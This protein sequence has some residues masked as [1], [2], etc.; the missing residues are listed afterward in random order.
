MSV[1]DRRAVWMGLGIVVLAVLGLRLVPARARS[2]RGLG[3]QLE[4]QRRLVAETEAAVTELP[5]LEDSARSLKQK[6]GLLGEK[7]LTG[8][9]EAEAVADLQGRLGLLAARNQ[10]GLTGVAGIPDSLRAGSLRRVT[11]VVTLETDTEG[12]AGLL[13]D[14]MASRVTMVPERVQISVTN[15]AG[16][17]DSEV[18]RVE[19]TLSSWYLPQRRVG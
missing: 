17:T 5:A 12:L 3:E 9:T 18:L 13:A 1:R 6:V 10:V 19:L 16:L 2:M 11:A 14:L 4:V 8:Q 15:P 7:I